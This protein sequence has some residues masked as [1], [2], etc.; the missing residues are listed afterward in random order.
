MDPSAIASIPPILPPRT[1]GQSPRAVRNIGWLLIVL[2]P[3]LSVGMAVISYNLYSAI[4]TQDLPG[5]SSRWHGG[6]EFTRTAFELF[7][8]VFALG[9]TIFAG[10]LYQVRTGRRHPVLV[11]LVLIVAAIIAYLVYKIIL[12]K[13]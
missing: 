12:S 3:S 1:D 5:A 10:G 4:V 11:A 6:P 9:W 7:A 13:V 8:A 2:G